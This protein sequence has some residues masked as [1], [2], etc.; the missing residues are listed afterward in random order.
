MRIIITKEGVKQFVPLLEGIG[1]TKHSNYQRLYNHLPRAN[2]VDMLHQSVT[3]NKSKKLPTL[4]KYPSIHIVAKDNN[5]FYKKIKIHPKRLAI[6]QEQTDLYDKDHQTQTTIVKQTA[7]ILMSIPSNKEHFPTLINNNNSNS[8]VFG[9]L[10]DGNECSNNNN[11]MNILNEESHSD[12]ENGGNGLSMNKPILPRS[13]SLKYLINENC[14]NDLTQK[15]QAEQYFNSHD[16]RLDEKILRKENKEHEIFEQIENDKQT[17]INSNHNSL[18]EYLI[19]KKEISVSALKLLSSYNNNEDK[20]NKLNKSCKKLLLNNEEEK[21][22]KQEIQT[23]VKEIHNNEIKTFKRV[24]NDINNDLNISNNKLNVLR[25]KKR[26]EN[27]NVIYKHL[28]ADFKRKYWKHKDNFQNL[29]FFK[30]STNKNGFNYKRYI[31]LINN[32]NVSNNQLNDNQK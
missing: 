10:L 16:K 31:N 11:K 9:G 7:D 24:L 2:S 14:F 12:N 18:M 22:M 17:E 26:A 3:S 29:F 13:Y 5:P 4:R 30:G 20:M 6:P 28:Y 19:S 21:K 1:F 15:I 27:K 8:N 32:N 25:E 23:K